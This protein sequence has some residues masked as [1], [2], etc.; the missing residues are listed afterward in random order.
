VSHDLY[1]N[2]DT[3]MPHDFYSDSDTNMSHDFYSDSDSLSTTSNTNASLSSSTVGSPHSD[4]EEVSVAEQNDLKVTYTVAE[5][6]PVAKNQSKPG[7]KRRSI[8]SHHS[9][10]TRCKKVIKV[11]INS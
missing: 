1:S 7:F 4:I 5:L 9:N 6:L 11:L 3:N 2:S 8:W 10:K